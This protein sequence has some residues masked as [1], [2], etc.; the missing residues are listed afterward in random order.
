MGRALR[1]VCEDGA[2]RGEDALVFIGEGRG[3]GG[4]AG[5]AAAGVI[6]EGGEVRHGVRA[7]WWG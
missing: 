3:K 5:K 7:S 4:R 1:V 6:A 2:Y